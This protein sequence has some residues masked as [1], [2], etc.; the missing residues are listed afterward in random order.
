VA[1][2]LSQLIHGQTGRW[3]F[4]GD[5]IADPLTGMHAAL[6][7]LASVRAGGGHLLSLSLH[8]TVRHCL[9]FAGQAPFKQTQ[10][11]R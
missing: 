1:A 8:Q 11:A 3:L 9:T 2:G 6:A 4:C 7:A 5:A 10:H